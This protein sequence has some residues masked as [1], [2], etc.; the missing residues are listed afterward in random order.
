[1]LAIGF[2][3][4]TVDIKTVI[5][6]L[7]VI[8]FS[9]A[10]YLKSGNVQISALGNSTIYKGQYIPYQEVVFNNAMATGEMLI[11]QLLIDSA[12]SF[13]SA[14]NLMS[15]LSGSVNSTKILGILAGVSNSTA[16][17]HR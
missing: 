1:M 7:S 10:D 3:G 14:N 2:D 6:N 13:L 8:L 9:Q 17:Y 12:S 16:L 11:V 15:V 5:E 4:A